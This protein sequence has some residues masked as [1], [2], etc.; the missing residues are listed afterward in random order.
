M[1]DIYKPLPDYIENAIFTEAKL[2]NQN[3]LFVEGPTL[4][5]DRINAN[6]RK[7]P[8]ELLAQTINTHVGNDNLETGGCVGELNHPLGERT[9]TDPDRISHKFVDVIDTGECFKTKALIAES[10]V[11]GKQVSGLFAAGIRLGISSRAY[12]K[13]CL[14]D[15]VQIVERMVLNSLGDIV[16]NPSAPGAYLRA[17]MESIETREYIMIAGNLIVQNS[18]NIEHLI[19][20]HISVINKTPRKKINE[21]AIMIF[22]DFLDKCI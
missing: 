14:R 13:A 4:I 6:G 12:G 18:S 9:G 3:H 2:E 11:C 8:K 5:Y 10:T 21:A 19:E 16:F 7:Y 20:D 22:S 15:T 17:L 1:K